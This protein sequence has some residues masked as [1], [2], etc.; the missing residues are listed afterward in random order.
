MRKLLALM[1][2]AAAFAAAAQSTAR[3]RPPGTMPLDEPPP[4]PPMVEVD[5]ALEPQ[6]STR[7]EGDNTIQEYRVRGRLYMQKVTPRNG[8]PYILMDQKGDGTFSKQDN[9]LDNGNR[10]PQWVLLEF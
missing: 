5:P 8:L 4:P 3:P 9:T 7:T 1:L 2:L 10:V 6:V